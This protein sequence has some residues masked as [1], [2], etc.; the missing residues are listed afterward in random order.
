MNLRNV[1]SYNIGLD[2]GTGSVGW[3]VTDAA[4]DLLHFKG[5]P[6]WGSRIFPT[7][8]TAADARL[9][10]GQRRRYVRR[11]WRLD[12]LKQLFDAEMMKVDPEFFARLRNSSLWP[13]DR[14]GDTTPYHWPFF[15]DTDF[16]EVTY[17]KA[18]PTI[19]HLRV[20]LMETKE[21]V[22]LRLIYLALHNIVK[23]RG[24]F[25]Y[26]DNPGLSAR[27]AS[28]KDAVNAFCEAFEGWAEDND[29]ECD[30]NVNGLQSCLENTSNTRRE[31]QERAKGLFGLP[32]EYEKT[33]GK[34]LSQAFVGYKA[35]FK[36]LFSD[37]AEGSNFALSNDEAVE[38]YRESIPEEGLALFEAIQGVYSAFVLSGI[39]GDASGEPIDSG[40]LHG[41]AGRTISYCKVREYVKYG[42]DLKL[43][44]D[45]V[46]E[47]APESY[48]EFFRGPFFE[49]THM[50]NPGD[51]KG[52]TLYNAKR[53]N[54]YEDFK[55]DVVKL[56]EATPAKDDPRYVSMMAG[57]E[58]ER[59]LRRLKTSDNG[60]IPYQLHLEE[61]DAIIENQ[62]THYPFLLQEKEKIESLVSFRIPYYV[63]P[64]TQ[65]NAAK[66]KEGGN[67]FAWSERLPGKENETIYPWNWDSII[68]KNASA[69]KFIGR[70]TSDCT[71]LLNE[72]VLPKCSLLYEEFC[73]LN[74]LNGARWTQDGDDLRRFDFADREG[75]VEDLF[76][77]G[78]VTYKK[79]ADWMREHRG[80]TH[81]TVQGGQGETKFESRLS[82]Y[83]FFCKDVFHV[84][85]LPESDYPM[86][87]QIILWNTLF[88]DRSI[89]K[90]ELERV[91]GDR[92]SPEQIKTICRKRFTGWGQLSRKLLTGIKAD[93]DDGP[94]SI[95]DVLREGCP[96]YDH[97]SR[98]MVF[99]E[100]LRDDD[101]AFESLIARENEKVIKGEGPLSVD[102]LPGSPSVRRTV[103]QA[104]RIVE[105]IAR[106]AGKAPANIFIE[107]TREED[108]KKKGKRTTRRYDALMEAARVLKSEAPELFDGAGNLAELKQKGSSSL[109]DER[110]VL[111]FMQG[112]KS[113]YSGKPLDI[114]RLS[115]YQVDHIIPQSYVKDDS[116]ENKAL[117]LS[118]EN[119][120]KSDDLLIP[121]EVRHKMRP[122]WDALRQ[123]ELIGEK[124]HRNLLC[125]RLSDRQVKGFIARQ[126][127]ETS[128]IVKLSSM[129]LESRFPDTRILPVKAALSSELRRVNGYV[130]CREINDFHH[131]HDAL[132]ASEIGRFILIRHSKMYDNPIA[133][134][135]VVKR[136]VRA[137]A[138]E[139]KKTG[140]VPG[141]AGFIVSSF[142]RSGFDKETGV[143][144]GDD[145]WD[146]DFEC[147]RIRKFLNYKQVFISRMPEETSGAF[148]KDTIYSPR[149]KTGSLP[150]KEHLDPSRYGSYSSE[151]FAYFFLYEALG[152]K[153]GKRQFVFSTVPVR[154][155]RALREESLDEYAKEDAK[156]RGLEF[157]KV[158]RSKIYK[159]Q[160]VE[161]EGDRLY[162]TGLKSARNARQLAF[163]LK[164]SEIVRDLLAGKSSVSDAD[165]TGVFEEV[166]ARLERAC[167]RL[168]SQLHLE[169]YRDSFINA[170]E[171]GKAAV[172]KSL[173]ALA[174]AH[175]RRANLFPIGGK[176]AVGDMQPTYSKYARS[177]E[178]IIFIDQSVT[179]MFEKRTRI[180][181]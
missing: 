9:K 16:N 37:E 44:K 24:N 63:G 64:L 70:M 180:G 38:K 60:S 12:L 133:Y 168:S 149:V 148:W 53:G 147:D 139:A 122:Y 47:Y 1:D 98:T 10:R 23:T 150:V 66:D 97:R 131:A 144:F 29:I 91:Y 90:E 31:K 87:E 25:L 45:L 160:L 72:P 27:N 169:D 82:S 167:E 158:A 84:E 2:L 102:E 14:P 56:F 126:L 75:I 33:M 94:R 46:K 110:L 88:E 142:M 109:D 48:D 100:I 140:R 132:L 42:E 164:T 67:R 170:D 51:S 108:D 30:P 175:D 4:G 89:L 8:E 92:L 105:E 15:N 138:K 19:Y 159:Y 116:F 114:N 79:V 61:M 7:A 54:G 40:S 68:D 146:A 39:L 3:A 156:G 165:S 154:V 93:T 173:L 20:W 123:A 86:I 81:V 36:Y 135:Q 5:K 41:A 155:A 127:V 125:D 59:F 128:Q 52:Y 71:Y 65:K 78:T 143:I 181:L 13:D 32:K 112:G 119:Q 77:N 121:R 178:G 58:E 22:D 134:T 17:Y 136:F 85:E 151:Q 28:M 111:Y 171:S 141:T 18:F 157:V 145:V 49:G 57:F 95:M 163:D 129:M 161:I 43:L 118:S 117:V 69:Q 21:K 162:I 99:M 113:L 62:G 120:A 177:K 55:K 179:G 74:E 172:M 76:K 26:Q 166:V 153:N 6:T 104:T 103:N 152:K 80:H 34:V 137:Q 176:K 35:D 174:N 11:R 124:K 130:K 96:N 50:Y 107:V 83:I 101:L 106:I 115:E 73:V